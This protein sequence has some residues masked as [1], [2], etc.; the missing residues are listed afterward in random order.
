MVKS[1]LWFLPE[2]GYCSF[3]LALQHVA[4]ILSLR[5]PLLH[6]PQDFI[7]EIYWRYYL[8]NQLFIFNILCLQLFSNVFQLIVLAPLFFNIILQDAL[9]FS[10]WLLSFNNFCILLILILVIL[11]GVGF[12]YDLFFLGIVQIVIN[13]LL[14]RGQLNGI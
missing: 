11:S 3:H 10:V 12:S 5:H 6:V 7:K 4:N 9:R 1:L 14:L 8:P 2:H 13:F